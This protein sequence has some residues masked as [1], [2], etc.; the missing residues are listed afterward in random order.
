MLLCCQQ[1][2]L[3]HLKPDLE[4]LRDTLFFNIFNNAIL[5]DDMNSA[6]DYRQYLVQNDIR[7]PSMYTLQG[8]KVTSQ[9]VLDPGP[10]GM[11]PSRLD[12]VFGEQPSRVFESIRAGIGEYFSTLILTADCINY[13]MNICRVGVDQ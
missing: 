9:A 7:P 6:L 10:G 8:T 13:L 2:N 11:K 12:Y 1:V 3:L 4:S 5:F